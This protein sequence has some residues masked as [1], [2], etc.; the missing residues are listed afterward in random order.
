MRCAVLHAA[1]VDT[2]IAWPSPAK[3]QRYFNHL[4]P[5]SD[6]DNKNT[7]CAVVGRKG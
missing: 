2:R 5:L 4:Q 3:A 6:D 1:G 7:G